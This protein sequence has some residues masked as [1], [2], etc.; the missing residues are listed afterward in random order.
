MSN[1]RNVSRF[2]S[3]S[4]C[5]YT[6]RKLIVG[7][8]RSVQLSSLQW[9]SFLIFYNDSFFVPFFCGEYLFGLL[10]AFLGMYFAYCELFKLKIHTGT[11]DKH[12]Y[13]SPHSA[14]SAE[15]WSVS[16]RM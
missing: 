9:Y 4:I 2:P 12:L 13:D 5:I 3:T 7:Q 11:D 14:E 1:S 16:Q 6:N 10:G 8:Y 15:L